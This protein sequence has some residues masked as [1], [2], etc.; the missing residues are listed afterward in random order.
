MLAGGEPE[1]VTPG[2]VLSAVAVDERGGELTGS[3]IVWHD[4]SGAEIGRG[5]YLDLRGQGRDVGVV[6][7]VVRHAEGIAAKGWNVRLG[8]GGVDILHEVPDVASGKPAPPH[9][10][11]HPAPPP[12]PTTDPCPD[13]DDQKP[14]EQGPS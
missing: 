6:R 13:G 3:T 4:P 14:A 11:P 1:S 5:R 10:H 12:P 9:E 8:T 7:A 2:G